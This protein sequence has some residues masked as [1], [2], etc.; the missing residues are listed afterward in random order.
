MSDGEQLLEKSSLSDINAGNSRLSFSQEASY[1]RGPSCQSRQPI[2]SSFV[3]QNG[4]MQIVSG[5]IVQPSRY[6]EAQNSAYYPQQTSGSYYQPQG[7]GWNSHGYRSSG[8]SDVMTQ[9]HNGYYQPHGYGWNSHGNN[10][11]SSI[12]HVISDVITRQHNGYSQPHGYGGYNQPHGYGGHNS[13]HFSGGH[14]FPRH[15]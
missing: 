2:D 4:D 15:R 11:S 9:Q 1:C 12:P 3:G 14:G 8:I 13:R 10:R 7:Y 6:Y 5:P